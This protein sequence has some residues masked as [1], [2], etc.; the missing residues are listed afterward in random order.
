MSWIRITAYRRRKA[1]RQRE[2]SNFPQDLPNKNFPLLR[3]IILASTGGGPAV[4]YVFAAISK[5]RTHAMF[6][7][8][9]RAGSHIIGAIFTDVFVVGCTLGYSD[10]HNLMRFTS[11][12]RCQIIFFTMFVKK[13][14]SNWLSHF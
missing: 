10:F 4:T 14:F 9:S 6:M 11:K 8:T 5:Y 7:T 3:L 1:K 2:H 13:K 12:K